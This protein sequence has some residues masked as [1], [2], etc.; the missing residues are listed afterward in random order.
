MI[1][2]LFWRFILVSLLAFGGG[3]AALPLVERL[4]VAETG[5]PVSKD[6][7]PSTSPGRAWSTLW[8]RP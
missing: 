8:M 3:Q 6:I 2:E 4:T 7:S 5:W 1:L